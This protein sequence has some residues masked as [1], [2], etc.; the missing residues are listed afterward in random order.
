[1]PRR[2]LI[3][4]DNPVS[5][6]MLELHLWKQGYEP[7]LAQTGREALACLETTSDIQLIIADIIMP[8]MNGLEFLRSMRAN[9]D[10]SGIPV[11]MATSLAD[12]QTIKQAF[13]AGCQHYLVKPIKA[14][15]LLEKVRETLE[16]EARTLRDK[17]DVM[18]EVGLDSE[19]YDEVAQAFT[20]QVR[21]S[22]T[23][24]EQPREDGAVEGISIELRDLWEGA[25][26]LG[27]EKVAKIL[28]RCVMTPGPTPGRIERA[29]YAELLLELKLVHRA[30]THAR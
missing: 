2:I 5:A 14:A 29:D 1:M 18:L 23:Q 24:L 17:S 16:H 6:K 12:V 26:L 13:E 22:I 25:T 15:Q 9:A 28:D 30:L 3:V 20:T 21:D 7:L 8:E 4:E 11:I 19:A 10:W 27:A